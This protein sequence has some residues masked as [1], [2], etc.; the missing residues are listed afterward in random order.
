MIIWRGLGWLVPVI[1]IGLMLLMQLAL[2]GLFGEGTYQGEGWSLWLT[3]FLIALVVG[4]FGVAAN[5]REG[6]G[7]HPP[8]HALFFIP[9]QYWALLIPLLVGLGSYFEGEREEQMAAY[10]AEPRV[11]DI[12]LMDLSSAFDLEDPAFPYGALKVV[13][14]NSKGI[15][16][17]V[18]EYQFDQRA[19]IRNAL[20]EQNAE[21]GFSEDTTFHFGFDEMEALVADDVVFDIQRF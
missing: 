5:H 11:E 10:L 4:F 8:Q 21:S 6:E 2:D 16:V 9:I 1:A 15:K 18:S 13:A 12:Y 14:V 20:L 17:V 7:P 3:L 19:G